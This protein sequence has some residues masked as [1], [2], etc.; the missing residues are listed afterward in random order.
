MLILFLFV[1]GFTVFLTYGESLVTGEEKERLMP[2]D[3]I[4]NLYRWTDVCNVYVLL[5]GE[6]ALLIDLGNGSVL[7]HL[8]GI[9]VKQIDWVLF[10]HHHLEQSM[11]AGK[12]SDWNARIAVPGAEREYFENPAKFRK[13]GPSNSDPHTVL[14]VSYLRPPIE[15]IAVDRSF[16]RMDTFTWRGYH[17][18]CI[19][20][21]GNS[22]GSMTYLLST[23]G[24]LAAFSGDVILA[25]AKMHNFPD[26]EWDY[27]Y[28]KGIRALHNSA[29]L[30]R[31]YS[32]DLLL[33]SHGPPI[34]QPLDDLKLYMQKLFD[35]ERL[36]VRGYDVS[37]YASAYQDM[38]SK[39]TVIPFL[40]QVSPH[41]FKFRG[42]EFFPNFSLILADSGHALLV[43]CGLLDTTLLEQTLESMKLHYGLKQIDAVIVTHIHGDH[44]LQVP[45]MQRSWGTAVWALENMVPYMEQPG[46]YNI[47]ALLPAYNAGFDTIRVDRAFTPGETFDW[48][49]YRFTVDWMPGQT[50]FALCL[51]GNIDGKKVAFTGDNIFGDAGNPMHTGHEA[52]VSR[53]SSVL[54]EGY[55]YA[56]ESMAQLQPD[57]LI[58]GHSFVM[59]APREMILRFRDWAYQMR[60]CLEWLSTEGDYRYW[61]D[62]CWVKA[63]PYRTSAVRGET[64]EIVI[65][66]RNFSEKPRTF[67]IRV[68]ASAGLVPGQSLVE[69]VVDAGSRVAVPLRIS[70]GAGAPPGMQRLAFDVTVDGYHY[71]PWFDALV[72]I[73]D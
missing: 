14:G 62:P 37:T 43:D 30:L 32:P 50:E 52:V 59:D 16:S 29:A 72:E 70:T 26:S 48:H 44:F 71:G 45:F 24:S 68:L 1:P 58:G 22:P 10:T 8:S 41:I 19:E 63:V 36:L 11:G 39:P 2:V 67:N 34:P 5:D 49:G 15:P 55:I 17:F 54:E 4:A 35:L 57:I 23:N 65:Q 7:S 21:P 40:W 28:G 3:G 9:G 27:G 46:N 61:Y 25:G 20:T 42:P 60:D 47:A 38:V 69:Q 6:S 12:L 66:L 56:A 64:A 18:T 53:N 31:D 13:S 51:H 33:P 73:T